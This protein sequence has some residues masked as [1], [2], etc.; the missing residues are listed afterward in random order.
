MESLFVF[1]SSGYLDVSVLQ[2]CFSYLLNK[3][4]PYIGRVG[5][6]IQKFAD[7]IVQPI[8]ATYRSLSRLSSPL[9]A[10][11]SPIRPLLFLTYS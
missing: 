1:S 9:R 11:A 7:Q 5:C 10:K 4:I 6:P 8:P 3:E 2:V